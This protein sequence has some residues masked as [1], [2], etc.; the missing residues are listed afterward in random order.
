MSSGDDERPVRSA[1]PAPRAVLVLVGTAALLVVLL[2]LH[3]MA[4]LVAPVFLAM[5]LV[6]MVHP[7]RSVLRGRHVPGGVV[8]VSLLLVVYGSGSAYGMPPQY[9]LDTDQG[10]T[11]LVYTERGSYMYEG[12]GV[13]A[14]VTDTPGDLGFLRQSN[15]NRSGQPTL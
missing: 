6:V 9:I 11:E 2:G 15:E 12:G 3:R 8:D 1:G 7:L 5:V 10:R 4:E 13:I 14:M